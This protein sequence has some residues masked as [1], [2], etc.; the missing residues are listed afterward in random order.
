VTVIADLSAGSVVVRDRYQNYDAEP[1]A[2]TVLRS[3]PS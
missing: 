2:P 3:S 1:F